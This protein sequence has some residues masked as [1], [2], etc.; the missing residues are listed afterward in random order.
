M[1]HL[2]LQNISY[3][4]QQAIRVYSGEAGLRKP[5]A[6]TYLQAKV[7]GDA[8]WQKGKKLAHHYK[9]TLA[10]KYYLKSVSVY[11]SANCDVGV[12]IAL[13]SLGAM[14]IYKGM[15]EKA[16]IY[17][18]KAEAVC[19]KLG[20]KPRLIN[21]INNLGLAYKGLGQIT[22]C[23]QYHEQCLLFA[24]ETNDELAKADALGNLGIVKTMQG[25]YLQ[26]LQFHLNALTIKRN[27]EDIKSIAN[28]LNNIGNIYYYT[29]QYD[30]AQK[31][32]EEVLKHRQQLVDERGCA[33]AFDNLGNVCFDTAQYAEALQY[34]QRAV[35]INKRHG[36][37]D[38]ICSGYGYLS[39]CYLHLKQPQ[40]AI[41]YATLE[42]ALATRIGCKQGQALGNMHLAQ[43]YLQVGQTGKAN[44]S[45]KC[46]KLQA[47]ELCAEVILMEAEEVL[48]QINKIE[49][50][51]ETAL[52]H[53]EEHTKIWRKGQNISM[54]NR[55]SQLKHIKEIEQKE[56]EN[57]AIEAV[58]NNVL[59][60][61]I[62]ARVKKGEQHI[63]ER[64]ENCTVLFADIVGFTQWSRTMPVQ[65]LAIHLNN[66]FEAFDELAALTG[67]EKIKTI[68]DA[69]MCVAGLPEP[70]IDHAERMAKM[71]LMMQQKIQELYPCNAV[72]LRIGMHTG[73]VVAGVIGKSR[74]SY[75]LW[76]DTVN[77]ASR[78][79][80]CGI[81]G[82]I[83]V[84]E[85]L[86]NQLRHKFVFTTRGK[87][88]V[89]GNG[90]MTTYLLS[91][92]ISA[93]TTCGL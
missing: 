46:A 80:S 13:N 34:Y 26:A 54:A 37:M 74:L 25:D 20:D 84:T 81:P 91:N 6:K 83:Q 24:E 14:F 68:G 10:E 77:I 89:K 40:V 67:V 9:Y 12:S 19:N 16:V 1:H 49:G 90:M 7:L 38:N 69:Y 56:R 71:A 32:Y 50:N 62:A 73:E 82:E 70:C 63:A 44:V 58:L 45:A 35:R 8:L 31:Y 72:K 64:F 66:V 53:Y 4:N 92:I 11:E 2:Q 17:L 88:E 36:N 47:A 27:H 87:V 60:A 51:F 75:D 22:K 15:Y 85:Q 28:T 93:K 59:P 78:M 48:Y 61:K 3:G 41:R 5:A 57:A 65:Q 52:L 21:V 76:G 29:A 30:E 18:H 23:I 55:I 86:M 33:V 43:S 79:E 42:I 39:T